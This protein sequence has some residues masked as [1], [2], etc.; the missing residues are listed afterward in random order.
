MAFFGKLYTLERNENFEEFIKSL[1]LPQE[2]SE[3][4]INSKPSQKIEK[5]GDYYII[6][7]NSRRGTTEIKFKD[8]VEFDEVFSPEI[9][10]KNTI[11]VDGNKFTQVQ[12]LGDKSVTYVREYTPEQLVVTVTSNFWDGIA[13][14]YYVAN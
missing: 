12:S 5:D 7:T 10:T 14:R 9:T 13:K 4:F 1:N 11:T 3:G 8:G 2:Q 6:T